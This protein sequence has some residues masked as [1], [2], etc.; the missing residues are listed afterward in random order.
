MTSQFVVD[1]R[2]SLDSTLF[3]DD[4]PAASQPISAVALGAYA[5]LVVTMWA[6]Y[7]MYSGLPAETGFVYTSEIGSLVGGFLYRFDPMRIHTKTFYHLPYVTAEVLGIGGSYVPF[8]AVH[9]LLWWSRGFLL[10]LIVRRLVADPLV[11]YVAGALLLVHSSDAATQWIGQ[12]NQFGFIFWMLLGFYLFIVAAETASGAAA[13]VLTAAACVSEYMSL[14]SYESPILLILVLP[15]VFLGRRV[16]A[17][18][19]AAISA[20][21][22]AIPAVYLW[23]TLTRYADVGGFA[24]QAT[25]VRKDWGLAN[26][27]RDWWFNVRASLE[28]WRWDAAVGTPAHHRVLLGWVAA[29]VFV[30]GGATI[31]YVGGEPARRNFF[32][33]T[34]E[35]GWRLLCVGFVALALSFPVYLML[36]SASSLWRTQFLSG[37]GAALVLTG[38]IMVALSYGRSTRPA[39]TAVA[40]MLATGVIVWFGSVA[41]ID[42]GAAQRVVWER[43]RSAVAR[44]LA[45]APSVK[46]NTI[47]VLVN[48]PRAEDPFGHHMWLDLAVR[49]A[50]PGI[51]VA[52][53]YFYADRTPSPGSNLRID[54]DRWKWD[55]TGFPPLVREASLANTVIVDAGSPAAALVRSIPDFLC[56]ARCAAQLYDP[57][58]VTT[59]PISPRAVRRYRLDGY[60]SR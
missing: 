49:L 36:E 53:T 52:A 26:L 39:G 2:T 37:I 42:K 21:W 22:Y 56:E 31:R 18:R 46:P 33:A 50:Y 8:Q 57:T 11:A 9:A 27:L 25:V 24:Y 7:T 51:P 19:L 34:R 55:G 32:A 12:M 6:P 45:V 41:A 20:A 5:L 23:L 1:R 54:G 47:I 17:A 15:F 30:A 16:R 3:T 48:V 59:G 60:L 14:W 44:I 13:L 28:F 10:F 4:Q 58:A 40:F 43:H 29:V 35:R 38:L